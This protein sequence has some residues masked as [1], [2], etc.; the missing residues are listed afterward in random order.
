MSLFSEADSLRQALTPFIKKIVE[1]S[2]RECLR[3][4]KAKV[5]SAP[6]TTTGKCEVRMMGQETVLSLPYSTA[7][8]NIAAEDYVWIATTNNSWR[9]AIVWKKLDFTEEIGNVED[10]D[11]SNYYTKE[12][13]KHEIENAISE[14]E[15][16]SYEQYVLPVASD[17]VLGGIKTGTEGQVYKEDTQFLYLPVFVD[18]NE[19]AYVAERKLKSIGEFGLCA[20]YK[21]SSFTGNDIPAYNATSVE[22]RYYAVESWNGHLVVNV[23]WTADGLTDEEQQNISNIPT[24]ISKVESFEATING[25]ADVAT[26]GSYEDLTNKPTIPT[27]TSQLENDSI[28]ELPDVSTNDD[29][30]ILMVESGKWELVKIVTAED[31]EV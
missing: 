15:F 31:S 5:V 2:T 4:Y 12:E 26:S 25:L 20:V 19:K 30:K 28:N 29:G 18:E 8:S 1:E 16:P 22:G 21:A 11:L 24:L 9:N 23:P 17:N 6:N 7:V 27:K 3:T 13:T 14:I 10:I